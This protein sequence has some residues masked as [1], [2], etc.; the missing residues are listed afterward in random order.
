MTYWSVDWQGNPTKSRHTYEEN[1]IST[2]SFSQVSFNVMGWTRFKKIS[3]SYKSNCFFVWCIFACIHMYINRVYT[4]I[5]Q[6]QKKKWYF[7]TWWRGWPDFSQTNQCQLLSLYDMAASW[8]LIWNL[9][10]TYIKHKLE[11]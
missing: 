3:Y 8:E 1:L 10:E 2:N 4:Y 9:F 7:Y 6:C 11:K 5:I